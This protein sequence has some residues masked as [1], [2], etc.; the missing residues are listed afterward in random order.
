MISFCK[1]QNQCR[2]NLI[3]NYF[4]EVESNDCENCSNC[5]KYDL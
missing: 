5:L 2:R 1:N 3:L 4:D